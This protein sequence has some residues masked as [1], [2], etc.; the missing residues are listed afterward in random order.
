MAGVFTQDIN[1][2]LRV[3]SEFESGMVGVNCMSLMFFTA[4]FSGSKV[5]VG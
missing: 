4:P 2:A 5:S 1:K 3:A